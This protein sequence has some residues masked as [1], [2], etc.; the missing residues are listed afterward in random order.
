[1]I[2]QALGYQK[3]GMSVIPLK[4]E[5]KR[6]LLASWKDYQRKQLGIADLKGFWKEAPE[7]NIGIVTGAISGITVV[8]VDGDEGVESL[9]KAG[10]R[11]PETY[12]VKT[13]NGWHFYYKYNN[14]FKTG[15]GFL[16]HVDVRNDAGYVVAP[17]SVF[18]GKNYEV[19]NENDGEFTEFENVPQCFITRAG[20]FKQA[21]KEDENKEF[22]EISQALENGVSSGSRNAMAYQIARYLWR[23]GVAKDII[24]S[25][26]IAYSHK[27]T[28]PMDERELKATYQ[29]AIGNA[30][31]MDIRSVSDALVTEPVIEIAPNGDI[32]IGWDDMGVKV[33]MSKIRKKFNRLDCMLAV[34]H[35]GVGEA[36]GPVAFDMTSMSKRREAVDALRKGVLQ[37]DYWASIIDL[38]CRIGIKSQ[39]DT[40]E[41]VNLGTEKRSTDTEQWLIPDFIPKSEPTLFYADSGTGKSM[42]ALTLAMSVSTGMPLL[43]GIEAPT[44]AGS[45]LYL[46]WETN[47]QAMMKRMDRVINGLNSKRPADRQLEPEDFD[48]QYVRCTSSLDSMATKIQAWVT[49]HACALIVI[50]SA[51]FAVG[52]TGDA[53]DSSTATAFMELVRSFG[54]TALIVS[55]VS[56]ANPKEAIGST[57]WKAGARNAWLLEKEQE[58]GKKYTDVALKHKKSNDS[59]LFNPIGLRMSFDKD[60]D[61]LKFEKFKV[62]ES[63]GGLAKDLPA[64]FRIVQLLKTTGGLTAKEIAEE[65]EL[66][67]SNV[68]MALNRGK[69]KEFIP[70][71]DA[72]GKKTWGLLAN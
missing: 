3:R 39:E 8:D 5:D 25:A 44:E 29:S 33:S 64:R 69:N 18:D 45:V 2:Q 43:D 34:Y 37:A 57:F 53:N 54:C 35:S 28:P 32:S 62:T 27:C 41:F 49:K 71:V 9:S 63:T 20:S 68:S 24:W 22:G 11:L 47:K 7:A 14:L 67:E 12:T 61:A 59:E 48:V 13:P 50:D 38:A 19:V 56:K 21:N 60:A 46:D 72:T 16:N 6:P 58:V 26:L 10:I 15:A 17:P 1:M 55:H 70:I 31:R 4:P 42:V 51:L 30:R 36:Y 66:S 40:A 65:L 52:N 23:R